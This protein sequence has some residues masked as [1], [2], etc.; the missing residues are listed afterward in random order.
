MSKID[1]CMESR[2]HPNDDVFERRSGTGN[3]GPYYEGTG[4]FHRQKVIYGLSPDHIDS[5]NGTQINYKDELVKEFGGSKE[6]INSASQ[7]LQGKT[8]CP[9]DLS[10]SLEA[11]YQVADRDYE[12]NTNWGEKVGWLYGSKSE[13]VLTGLMTAGPAIS[14][15]TCRLSS[16]APHQA[17]SLHQ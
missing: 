7:A 10:N 6:F 11:A 8:D 14:H 15:R 9:T 2:G 12:S 17:A 13:D 3:S 4:C 5:L 1:S 16:V